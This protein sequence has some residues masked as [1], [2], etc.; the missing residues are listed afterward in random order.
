[1][2]DDIVFGA[3]VH[4]DEADRPTLRLRARYDNSPQDVWWA[5]TDDVDLSAW[6]PW[7]V[8]IDPVSG[9]TV[10]LASAGDDTTEGEVLSADRPRRLVWRLPGGSGRDSEMLRWELEEDGEGCL[11]TFDATI[12][13][14]DHATQTAA[15]FDISLQNLG[16][17]LAEQPVVRAESPSGDP[18]FESL[19]Q[20]YEETLRPDL[21]SVT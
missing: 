3:G 7:Q 20:Y 21:D 8:V 17:L 15:G 6:T 18:R 4:R 1:M 12:G 11:L 16:A 10:T 9:G 19:V 14:L 13:D 2:F 5:L